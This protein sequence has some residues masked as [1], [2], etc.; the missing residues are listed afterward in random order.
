MAGAIV[1]LLIGTSVEHF[2]LFLIPI[3]AGHFI[4]IATADIIPELH[5]ETRIGKSI[6]QFIGLLVG[7]AIMMLLLLLE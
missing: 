1:G 3:T 5:K 2:A 4:Y 6:L 7:I